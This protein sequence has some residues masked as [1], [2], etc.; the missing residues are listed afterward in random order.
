MGNGFVC[1]AKACGIALLVGLLLSSVLAG[2]GLP[3]QYGRQKGPGYWQSVNGTEL[4]ARMFQSM[5]HSTETRNTMTPSIDRVDVLVWFPDELSPMDEFVQQRL[6]EWLQSGF[7]KTLVIVGR[8]YDATCDYW[9]SVA[10]QAS[11]AEKVE[12]ERQWALAR[13]QLMAKRY[14][15]G[16]SFAPSEMSCDWFDVELGDEEVGTVFGGPWADSVSEAPQTAR[17]GRVRWLPPKAKTNAYGNWDYA[18]LLDVNG[19]PFAF[20]MTRGES[21]VIVI[22]NGS[23]FLN[24]PLAQP[25]NQQFVEALDST[26]NTWGDI[27]FLESGPNGLA[28][29]NSDGRQTMWSWISEPPLRF[30]VPHFLVWGVIACFVFYPIFGRPRR[31]IEPSKSGFR[32]HV[33]AIGELLASS[34]ETS[35]A[36]QSISNY[37]KNVKP[38]KTRT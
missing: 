24:Y 38:E 9:K 22:N 16:S 6:R 23:L 26:I 33:R 2:Q 31:G 28:I 21:E 18:S 25:Q 5:G 13:S 4:L 12:A 10:A 30:L 32:K 7:S 11:G 1:W 29:S 19:Q 34:Q 37:Q 36:Q 14:A 20:S 35:Y 3:T 8:D 15:Q 27:V 17:F